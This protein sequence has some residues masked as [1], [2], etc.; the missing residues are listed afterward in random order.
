MTS[1]LCLAVKKS[2]KKKKNEEREL[3]GNS[4]SDWSSKRVNDKKSLI[5]K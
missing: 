1:W 2:D 5:I 3:G 4:K